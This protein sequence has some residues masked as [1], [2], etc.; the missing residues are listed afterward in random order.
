MAKAEHIH[1][2]DWLRLIAAIS[3]IYM[4]VASAPLRGSLGTDWHLINVLTSIG[5][6]AVP[7]FF[8]MSGHLLLSNPKTES[9]SVLLR[10]RLPR[11]LI[12]LAAWTV[13]A[14]LWKAFLAKD[15]T[16]L[17]GEFLSSLHTP[18]WIH[19]WYMYTLIALYILAPLLCAGLRSLSRSGHILIFVL[20]CLPSLRVILQALLPA[21][22][23]KLLNL[24]IITKLTFFGGHLNTFLLGYYL[25]KSEKRIP[26]PLLLG[27]GGVTLL[28]I[29][30]GTFRL[31]SI[32]GA[33]D[34]TFMNQSAGFEVLLA[35]ILFLLFKQNVRRPSKLLA[36]LP[37]VPLSL[38][39]YLM[40]NLLLSAMTR[41]YVPV[42]FADTLWMTAVNLVVCFLTMKTVATVKPLCFLLTGMRFDTACKTC[43]WVF[44]FRRLKSALSG[45][46]V[47]RN[48]EFS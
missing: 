11:L 16:V 3:V 40:H 34:S 21:S 33:F 17:P 2:F 47:R 45:K 37:I 27:A 24:D 35:A 8:M 36:S 20:I 38:P 42:T 30:F 12:P 41:F 7:L 46:K 9:P 13:I 39:I 32:G 25:G 44:T 28:T 1:G 5:F 6:T 26:V 10:H 18:A 48:E 29:I 15:L 31:T 14:I 19:F 43:N 22:L 23:D 4:H